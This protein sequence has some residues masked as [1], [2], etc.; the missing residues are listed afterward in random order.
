MIGLGKTPCDEGV[1]Y[2]APA[3]PGCAEHV[4]PWVLSA[5]ILGSSM[6][7]IDGSVVNVALP[8][9]QG[10]LATSI[11][12][13][14]WVVNAYL[15]M[16]GAL[17]LLGGSAG[18]RF[19][20][21]RVFGLGV[22]VF[23]LAS[24][25]CGLA[26]SIGVLIVARVVQGIGAAL[27]VPGSLAIISASFREAE[28][29]RAIG[30]WAGFSAITAALGPVLGGWIVD[31]WS[32]RV[33]FF[34]NVP[35][36]LITLG[37][38]F[39]HVPE[40][41]D[42]EDRGRLDWPGAA[43]A[44]VGL[45]AVVYG[46]S[47]APRHGWVHPAVL[48]ALVGGVVVL[49]AFVNAESRAAAPMMPLTLFRSRRF[50]GTNGM[51][52]LLYAALGG[53]LFFLPFYLID[54]RGYSAASAGAAFLPFTVIMGALSRWSGG[55]LDRYGARIPLTVGPAIAA[56]GFALFALLDGGRSYWTTVFPAM[57]I[58]GLGMAISVAPLTTTVMDSV[59]PSQA[60]TASGVNNAASRIA[61]MVAIA[62]FG[63]VAVGVFGPALDARLHDIQVAPAIRHVLSAQTARLAEV[64]LPP[65]VTG[66]DREALRR[67]VNQSFTASFQVVMFTAA[68]LALLS[69]L[70]AA[71][72]IGGR[73]RTE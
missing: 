42:E 53:M 49:A 1:V 51:T 38:V 7:F 9:I 61:G 46:L 33:I 36:A 14:Q 43:L 41:R 47:A 6:A 25:A 28:R 10:E 15:L 52:L 55:L 37:I 12:G 13:A 3:T 59:Q 69:A 70:C 26:A 21:R 31:A 32:W 54:V 19:G 23:T 17:V 30:T 2:A 34:I 66:S 65:Q 18:D 64:K 73:K 27:L 11:A 63:A 5:T 71:L 68:G 58:V 57:V 60:G 67:A 45:G 4:K 22:I 40:S 39:R 72:T 44:A 50:S 35:L 16:L 8:A 62:V 29:G 48:G 24:V 20:R 56:L